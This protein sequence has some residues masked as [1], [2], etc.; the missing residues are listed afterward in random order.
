MKG[1]TAETE[2]RTSKQLQSTF[3]GLD[4]GNIREWLFPSC[5]P[6][7]YRHWLLGCRSC[8]SECDVCKNRF[9]GRAKCV[10]C[11]TKIID[12]DGEC[13]YCA[14]GEYVTQGDAPECVSCDELTPYC[15]AC[16]LMTG[17]CSACASPLSLDSKF[18][19]ACPSGQTYNEAKERCETSSTCTAAQ[20]IDN[21]NSCVDCSSN[22]DVCTDLTGVCT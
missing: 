2:T 18:A 14:E 9:V 16:E 7:E 20:Y 15:I 19:C 17:K 21:M 22:C 10:G 12:A 1:I 3:A 6:A 4:F 8:P 5:E 13:F 11:S